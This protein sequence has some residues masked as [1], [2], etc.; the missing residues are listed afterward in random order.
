MMIKMATGVDDDGDANGDVVMGDEV[1]DDG[2]DDDD[3]DDGAMSSG[4]NRI[5]R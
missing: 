5:R 1:D 4:A 3:N 2:D